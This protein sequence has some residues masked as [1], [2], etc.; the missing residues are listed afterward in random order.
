MAH[1]ITQIRDAVVSNLGGMTTVPSSRVFP[2]R[3]YPLSDSELPCVLVSAVGESSQ[4]GSWGNGLTYERTLTVDVDVCVS[5]RS[6]FDT[7][8]NQIQ[9]EVE[10]AIAADPTLG[11]IAT[12]IRYTGRSKQLSGDGDMPFISLRL[13]FDVAYRADS[14][15]PDVAV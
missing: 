15:A 3:L 14:T 10:K 5:A 9:L 4:P 11:G 7:E 8:A 13:N 2:D 6:T 12:V 1:L